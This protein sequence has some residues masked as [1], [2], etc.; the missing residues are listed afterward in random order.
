MMLLFEQRRVESKYQAVTRHTAHTSHGPADL[1]CH[2]TS[3]TSPLI[4][5]WRWD[6]FYKFAQS[7]SKLK[8][9]IE[10]IQSFTKLPDTL[11]DPVLNSHKVL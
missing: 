7:G 4:T 6:K 11:R 2:Q 1:S 10:D 8:T 5:S 3:L 9:H